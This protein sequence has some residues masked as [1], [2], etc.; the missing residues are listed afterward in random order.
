MKDFIFEKARRSGIIFSLLAFGSTIVVIFFGIGVYEALWN[1]PRMAQNISR[2]EDQNK[3]W[4]DRVETLETFIQIQ[5]KNIRLERVIWAAS[6]EEGRDN[7]VALEGCMN[8][9]GIGK[10]GEEDKENQ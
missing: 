7:L 4:H 6:G 1:V 9:I 3:A 2:L 8:A 10:V 5:K